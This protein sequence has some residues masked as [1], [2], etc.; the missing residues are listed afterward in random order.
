MRVAILKD[1]YIEELEAKANK[2]LEEIDLRHGR[3]EGITYIANVIPK[4]R[5]DKVVSNE[6]VYSV[7]ILYEEIKQPLG[8]K[9]EAT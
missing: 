3:A 9:S 6:V 1:T 7:M 5:G 2:R 8:M 4:M